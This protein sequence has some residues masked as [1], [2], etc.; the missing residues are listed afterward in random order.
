MNLFS[1]TTCWVSSHLQAIIK[2][3]QKKENV[4]VQVY[5]SNKE[6]GEKAR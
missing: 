1:K 4:V 5:G 3:S 2:N 6:T